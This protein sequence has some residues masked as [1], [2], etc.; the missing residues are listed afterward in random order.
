MGVTDF[1]TKL[2]AV[3]RDDL[4]QWQRLNVIAFL[5]SGVTAG[6][7]DGLV[8]EPYEDADGVTYLPMSRQPILIFQASGDKLKTVRRRA[9]EREVPIAIY[10]EELFTTGKDEDN[11]AEVKRH[12]TEDLNLVG[13][14]FRADHRPADQII[15]GLKRHP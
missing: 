3:V 8:G 10:T 13:L 5:L 6:S 11:R 12:A 14:A 9:L 15:R 1:P 4:E 2:A 7:D